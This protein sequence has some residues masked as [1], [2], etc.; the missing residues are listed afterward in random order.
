MGTAGREK[1]SK[2]WLSETN[3]SIHEN[4]YFELFLNT[5]EFWQ[6]L[7]LGT[8]VWRNEKR[9]WS[10]VELRE[11]C[12]GSPDD[13]GECQQKRK[14]LK[15]CVQIHRYFLQTI[16]KV[17]QI[18]HWH[19]HRTIPHRWVPI[20]L[21]FTSTMVIISEQNVL[22]RNLWNNH[23]TQ[24]SA[25]KFLATCLDFDFKTQV[26]FLVFIWNQITPKLKEF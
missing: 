2:C 26:R 4:S 7:Y 13:G 21:Q 19:L 18:Y 1:I 14:V 12:T 3:T 15:N 24:Y 17:D 23:S 22:V 10:M 9:W 20:P 11:S 5:S 16:T 6:L 8:L 25:V